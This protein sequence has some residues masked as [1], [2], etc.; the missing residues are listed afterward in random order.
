M[1]RKGLRPAIEHDIFHY[2]PQYRPESLWSCTKR[3]FRECFGIGFSA[4]PS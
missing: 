3:V 4:Q 1:H 2:D